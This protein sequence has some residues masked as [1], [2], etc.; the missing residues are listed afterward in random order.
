[1]NTKVLVLGNDPQ[2]NRINFDRLSPSVLTL[3]VNRIWLKHTPNYF[4]FND[5]EIARELEKNP[6]DLAKLRQHSTIFSSDWLSREKSYNIP[7]WVRVYHRQNKYSFPD[8]VSTA[9]H[10]FNYHLVKNCI[11]YVAGVSLKWQTPSH[12]WLKMNYSS[13]HVP[14]NEWYEPR[15]KKILQNFTMMK[16]MGINV[17]S[18]HPD[19]ELN[20]VMRYE[21][22]ENLYQRR[23]H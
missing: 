13:S 7:S 16:N 17:V 21:N 15:F 6:E 2:I 9:I 12:F 4:F 10:L 1:M 14:T 23:L 22:I 5:F 18:V 8:S 19:S 11:F 3:G 20:K